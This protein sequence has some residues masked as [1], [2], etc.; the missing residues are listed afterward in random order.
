MGL[1]KLGP[2][3]ANAGDTKRARR[4]TQVTLYD[5]GNGTT[6]GHWRCA[7]QAQSAPERVQRR[8]QRAGT[9]VSTVP[10]SRLRY[11]AQAPYLRSAPPASRSPSSGGNFSAALIGRHQINAKHDRRSPSLW[12]CYHSCFRTRIGRAL[13]CRY[14]TD[15][16]EIG[17]LAPTAMCL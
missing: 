8:R 9:S 4:W 16:R 14:T 10:R 6:G 15:S 17:P 2:R 12:H 1:S 13:R 7:A 11:A 3:S 5:R